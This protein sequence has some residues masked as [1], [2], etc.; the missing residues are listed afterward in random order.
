MD[1][2]R[3]G[4]SRSNGEATNANARLVRAWLAGGAALRR[5]SSCTSNGIARA[6]SSHWS[7]VVTRRSSPPPG[8]WQPVTA[9]R[10]WSHHARH[11]RVAPGPMP[12][13]SATD[14]ATALN[15]PASVLQP[16][17]TIPTAT[18]GHPATKRRSTASGGSGRPALAEIRQRRRPRPY[19]STRRNNCAFTAT[20]IVLSDISTAPTAGCST[21]P[22]GASA[23][24][25]SGMATML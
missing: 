13:I 11:S 23:P 14:S 15:T 18:A 4:G 21:T 3:S 16:A 17:K 6:P 10:C 2:A 7:A 20:T 19:S 25:A 5:A 12:T 9:A 1:S 8:P 22:H 24:A